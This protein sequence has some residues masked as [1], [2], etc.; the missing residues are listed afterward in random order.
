[1]NL[2]SVPKIEARYWFAIMLASMCGTNLGDFFPDIL[3]IDPGVEMVVLIALF[4]AILV[5]DKLLPRG[6]EALYWLAILMVR[7]AATAIGD[8]LMDVEKIDPAQ[9]GAFLAAGMGVLVAL[10]WRASRASGAGEDRPSV[11]GRYWVTMLTAGTLGTVMGDGIG[12]VFS[13]VQVGVPVSALLATLALAAIFGLRAR[14]AWKIGVSYWIAIVAVRWWGTNTGDIFKYLTSLPVSMAITA[15]AMAAVL[16][17][18][19]NGRSA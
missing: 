14:M 2:K 15:A 12:R 11:G 19:P 18:I 1:M 17:L 3:E 13:S 6:L 7:A 9:I 16:V 8:F 10:D 5:V 4:A